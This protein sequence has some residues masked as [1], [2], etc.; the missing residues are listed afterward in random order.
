[1][2]GCGVFL[3]KIPLDEMQRGERMR[4]LRFGRGKTHYYSQRPNTETRSLYH[5]GNQES[6]KDIVLEGE[7]EWTD[8]CFIEG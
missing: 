4:G 1:M 6:G 2:E 5:K 7:K 3:L 8:S